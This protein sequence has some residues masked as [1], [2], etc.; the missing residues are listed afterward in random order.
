[1]LRVFVRDLTRKKHRGRTRGRTLFINTGKQ[2]HT[3]RESREQK[4]NTIGIL[5]LWLGRER[6]T[7]QLYALH[8]RAVSVQGWC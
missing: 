3:A 2:P 6:Q 5:W 4:K 1:M 8:I 7:Y